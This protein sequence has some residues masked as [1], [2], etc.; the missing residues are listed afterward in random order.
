M[1][2]MVALTKHNYQPVNGRFSI[3]D[4]PGIGNEIAEETF[5]KSEIVTIQ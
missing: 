5:K 2:K 3:P 1:P 4:L